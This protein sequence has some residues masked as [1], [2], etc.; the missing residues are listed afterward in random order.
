MSRP[1]Y[2]AL[3]LRL[4]QC[5]ELSTLG[6]HL[7]KMLAENEH[8]A[9]LASGLATHTRPS[10]DNPLA[11]L[12]RDLA[13][14]YPAR[15]FGVGDLWESLLPTSIKLWT[16]EGIRPVV[17]MSS[18]DIAR[19]YASL[20]AVCV[21]RLPVI[22]V[23]AAGLDTGQTT[24]AEI[25]NDVAIL[26]TL[27]N[28]YIGAPGDE[29]EL[30]QQLAIA[31]RDDSHPII[32]RY[33]PLKDTQPKPISKL[34]LGTAFGI[35]KAQMLKEGKDFA[36]LAEGATVAVAIDLAE[37]LANKGYSAAVVNARW[38]KPLDEPLLGA[39][40]NYFPRLIT[41]EDG[42]VNGGFGSEVLELMERR[43]WYNVRIKRIG[44]SPNQN[45]SVQNLVEDISTFVERLNRL[46]KFG[47][48]GSDLEIDKMARA[49]Y[50]TKP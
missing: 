34:N 24:R 25:N 28:L 45:W 27:P 20:S 33:L 2:K 23:L 4:S 17:V 11:L 15:F 9:I 41:L 16:Q 38:I 19:S 43:G 29:A 26:R 8:L 42:D 3:N 30:R 39:I 46:E 47:G 36:I 1:I 32:L 48:L 5:P 13:K 6:K 31:A 49:G 40:V 22:F 14:N 7:L 18:A 37:E 44:L 10:P 21:A 50:N 35:G 12:V